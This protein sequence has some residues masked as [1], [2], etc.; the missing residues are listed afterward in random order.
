MLAQT[1]HYWQ[2]LMVFTQLTIKFKQ[3]SYRVTSLHDTLTTLI[4]L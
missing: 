3:K 2:E 4:T 1:Y